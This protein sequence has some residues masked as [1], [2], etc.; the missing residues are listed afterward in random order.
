MASEALGS[1]L[2]SKAVGYKITKGDFS[3]T[4][5]NLPQKVVIIGQKNTGGTLDADEFEFTSAYEVGVKFGFGSPLWQAARILRPIS[6]AGI[7]GIP[8]SILAQDDPVGGVAQ[9]WD[10]DVLGTATNNYTLDISI[11]GRS[12]VDGVSYSVNIVTGD[13][14]SEIATKINDSINNA[15]S[16]CPLTSSVST[17]T[18]S[19]ICRWQ[20][21]TGKDTNIVITP[22]NPNT[23]VTY[24]VSEAAVGSGVPTVTS[25]LNKIGN[26]WATIILNTYQFNATNSV[27]N[28]L[29]AWNGTPDP[30]TP[31]GRYAGSIMKPAIAVTGTVEDNDS[32]ITDLLL[33][34]VTIALAPAPL[35]KGMPCEAAANMVRLLARQAQDNPHLD[36]SG[37]SYPDMPTPT[38]IG[39]MAIYANRDSYVKKGNSTVD[40]VSGKYKIMDFV[41]TYHPL[42]EAVPQFRFVRSLVQDFNIKYGYTLLEELN[43]VDHA[44]AGDNDFVTAKKVVK[45]KTWKSVLF[46]YADDLAK[47]AIIAEPT[48]MQESITVGLSNSNPDRLETFFRY[49]RSGFTRIAS[50]TG[51]AGFNFGE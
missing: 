36:V 24:T 21:E 8:T 10:I 17:T 12:S 11:N 13:T 9:A 38:D 5:P 16:V 34:D 7:G 28:E 18:V 29:M 27:A 32:I 51:E 49:K 23:T 41:T 46:N 37:Y 47:R 19:A 44:I 48:F 31:T 6:G 50:T 42:G 3:D 15:Q 43:V 22:S 20:G 39:T 4:T 1:E 25:S 45:P 40:L 14:A 35:S 26:Q 2:I 30:N 33:D